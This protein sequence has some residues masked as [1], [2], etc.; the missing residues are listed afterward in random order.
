MGEEYL[1]DMADHLSTTMP[2]NTAITLVAAKHRII[3]AVEKSVPIQ[4][5]LWIQLETVIN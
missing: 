4:S 2:D 3:S 1:R 5:T